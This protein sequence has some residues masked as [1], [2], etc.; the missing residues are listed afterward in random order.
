MSGYA[1]R[2]LVTE[3][4]PGESDQ[5]G[6]TRL[7]L[8]CSPQLGCAAQALAR[9]WGEDRALP[10]GAVNRMATLV[11]AAVGHGLRFG[12]K[13]MTIAL[14]WLDLDRVL[15]DVTWHQCLSTAASSAHEGDVQSTM[16]VFDSLSP[17][18]GFGASD[19]GPAQWM[20]VDTR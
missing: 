18:W 20:V 8:A 13:S 5:I 12:P 3:P 19:S 6:I 4:A 15:I 7:N 17:T 11:A 16:A 14:R 2:S 1:Q 9:R 10:V